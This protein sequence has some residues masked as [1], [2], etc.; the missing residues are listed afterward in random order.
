MA[1]K[2]VSRWVP[3]PGTG[4]PYWPHFELKNYLFFSS[5]GHG[6]MSRRAK[7]APQPH[8]TCLT[9]IGVRPIPKVSTTV[10]ATAKRVTE[11]AKKLV[12]M[13][14]LWLLAMFDP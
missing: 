4:P 3:Y 10:V 7:M 11:K 12:K 14:I 1:Q 13:A 8:P 6:H 9:S 2:I 5:S